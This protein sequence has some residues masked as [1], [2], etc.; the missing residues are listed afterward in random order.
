MLVASGLAAPFIPI[1]LQLRSE[2]DGADA[3]QFART[4]LTG[5]VAVMGAVA[6][7]LFAFAEATTTIIAPGFAGEQRALYA[8]LFRVMPATPI[9][10]AASLTLGEVLLA[11]QRFVWYGLAPL[12]YNGGIVA[13][14]LLRVDGIGIFG[15]AI[16]AVTGALL[17]LGSRLVGLRRS[18]FRIGPGRQFRMPAV[19]EF[20]R[21][22]LPKMAS[23]RWSR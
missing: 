8:A 11:E 15:P 21:L 10:F 22:M 1:F 3:D 18:R 16:G 23:H 9:L 5:A 4:I 20:A 6:I 17:H 14:T 19:R 13:G 2:G 12:L 7:V